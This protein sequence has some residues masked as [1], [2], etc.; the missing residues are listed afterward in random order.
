[1]LFSIIPME[2][3][4]AKVGATVANP[5]VASFGTWYTGGWT[6]DNDHLN[7]YIKFKTSSQGLVTFEFTKPIDDEGEYGAMEFL[8]YDVESGECVW[9]HKTVNEKDDIKST[10]KCTLG[11]P[12][13]EYILNVAPGFYVISGYINFDFKLTITKT[14]YCESEPNNTVGEA[15]SIQLGKFYKGY[16]GTYT[17]TDYEDEYDYF[18]FKVKKGTK[19]RVRFKTGAKKLIAST[20]MLDVIING[21]EVYSFD[22]FYDMSDRYDNSGCA[23]SDFTAQASG[24]AYLKFDNYYGVPIEYEF[25][26]DEVP[27]KCSAPKLKSATNSTNG[28]KL[29]WG[30]VTGA[31]TYT[32][33]RKTGSDEW[34]TVK[35]GIKS[36]SYV[37][38]T[39]KSGKTYK[40]TVKAVNGAGKSDSSKSITISYLAA[41]K[42]KSAANTTSGVKL[43]WSK[44]TGAKKYYVYRKTTNGEWK[45][46]ATV[47]STSYTDKSAKSGTS[48]Q[49]RVRA[50]SGDN[51]SAYGVSISKRFL[52]APKLAKIS[53]SKSGVKTE[54]NK[55]KGAKGY[56][57]YRKSGSGDWKKVGTVS[58]GSKLSYRD[59]SAKK[60]VTY[61]YSVIAYNGKTTSA[62][63]AKYLSIKAK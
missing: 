49:Y 47:T 32:V 2:A 23:Y 53:A 45:K 40:Y 28:V 51:K 8:L 35:S 27:V 61:K 21:E 12:A 55:V 5:K 42:I 33:L 39:A 50:I 31:D 63:S 25:A 17:Y 62:R 38:T 44:V 13:G 52:S 7:Y 22:G 57:V 24:Y 10:T 9:S 20:A 14:K 56:Y 54:W 4:A 60:G 18:K 11:L 3:S 48:Y 36:T 34:K 16:F 6:K 29:T 59:K 19:Y 30:K 26:I 15:D 46:L 58:D 1:M 43:T 41:P 37:D